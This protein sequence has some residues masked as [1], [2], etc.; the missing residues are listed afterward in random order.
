LFHAH[1]APGILPFEASGPRG[2]AASPRRCTHLP[3][4]WCLIPEPQLR[5]GNARR[6]SWVL[7]LW[8]RPANSGHRSARHRQAAP[9][10][11][12]LLGLCCEL[13]LD[14]P[15]GGLLSGA[16]LRNDGFVRRIVPTC[17]SEC[18]SVSH[19][20]LRATSEVIALCFNPCRVF[21]PIQSWAFRPEHTGLW[22]HLV[23][24]RHY[25]RLPLTPWCA[26]V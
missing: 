4:I 13:T 25:C 10:G 20:K 9:L 11:F 18:R 8:H 21:A 19:W 15:S 23:S 26:D 24:R 6:G 1:S 3:L 7:T 17:T 16:W 22:V 14:S 12:A 5:Y 2:S